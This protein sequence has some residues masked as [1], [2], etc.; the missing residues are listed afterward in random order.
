MTAV[1]SSHGGLGGVGVALRAGQAA[2]HALVY[3]TWLRSFRKLSDFAKPVPSEIYYAAQH[4]RIERLL[5]RGNLELAVLPGDDVTALGYVVTEG[6]VLHWL[7]VKGP[8]RRLGVAGR[9]LAGKAIR[10]FS[11][12][13]F[14]FDYIAKKRKDWKYNPFAAER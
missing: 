1:L 9:L 5:S 3:A 8:W 2:D 12:L 4:D 13:T 14:D 10:E 11:H 6:P 7:Y